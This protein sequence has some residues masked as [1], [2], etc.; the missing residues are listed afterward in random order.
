MSTS[1]KYDDVSDMEDTEEVIHSEGEPFE[2]YQYPNNT[3]DSDGSMHEE[4]YSS[5]KQVGYMN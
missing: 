3:W 5:Y 4:N 2:G 1:S